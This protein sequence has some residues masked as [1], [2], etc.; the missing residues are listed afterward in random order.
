MLI[1]QEELA[2]RLAEPEPV[3]PLHWHSAPASRSHWL[4]CTALLL[5]PAPP[6][7]SRADAPQSRGAIML[8][9]SLALLVLGAASSRVGTAG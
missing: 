2:L 7:S 4:R 5:V 9:R 6:G 3:T 8:P 1:A